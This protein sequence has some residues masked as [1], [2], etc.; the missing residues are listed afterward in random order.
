[1]FQVYFDFCAYSDIAV[2]TARVLGFDLT[3]NFNRPYAARSVSDYWR[4]W[5]IS[6]TSWFL[7]YVFAPLAASLRRWRSGAVVAAL[8]ATFL[9]SGLWHGAQW[10]F[11][12]FGL[13]HSVA[14]SLEYLTSRQRKWLR[15]HF[16]ARAYGLFAWATTFA[17]LACVDVLFR[18]RSIGEAQAFLV[19]MF[20]GLV[21]DLSFLA[22]RHFTPAS[23]KA[24]IAGLPV[25]KIELVYAI[26]AISAAE[27]VGFLGKRQPVRERLLGQPVWVRWSAYYAVAAAIVFFG[28]HNVTTEFLYVQF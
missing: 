24:L 7:D 23:F 8:T 11:V 17:F 20:G 10:T 14:L 9:L 27:L 5:H 26:V 22:Q 15:K 13:A 1:M 2:G 6:L 21:P 12:L 18:A 4:R 3:W 25:L 16:P 28:T 19:R